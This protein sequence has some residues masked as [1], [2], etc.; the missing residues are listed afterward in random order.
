M[1]VHNIGIKVPNGVVVLKNEDVCLDTLQYPLIVKPNTDG[2]SIGI[3]QSSVVYNEKTAF[4]QIQRLF[5][6][7]E[8]VIVEEYI[9]G[10]ELT[11]LIVGNKQ[12]ICI[13]EIIIY[14][15]DYKLIQDK[16]VQDSFIKANDLRT[17]YLGEEILKPDLVKQIKETSEKI[18]FHIGA[19]DVARIDYRVTEKGDIFFLEINSAPRISST[20]DVGVIC[21]KTNITF[22][23]FIKKYLLSV[24]QR[25]N[26]NHDLK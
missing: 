9:K 23:Q 5:S 14:E 22:T 20:S 19:R 4:E 21:Q 13:N 12:N 15:M 1:A 2:S 17:S 7:Y 16:L 11:N 3:T 18:F 10:Y 8:E 6:D 25:L 24:L 26:L